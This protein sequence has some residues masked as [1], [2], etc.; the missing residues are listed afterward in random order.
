MAY[1]PLPE[2]ERVR[3]PKPLPNWYNNI[4]AVALGPASEATPGEPARANMNTVLHCLEKS[5][6]PLC[7]R[8]IVERV[9]QSEAR[10]GGWLM[11]LWEKGKITYELQ[12]AKKFWRLWHPGEV[13]TAPPPTRPRPVQEQI[14][15]H[16]AMT[17]DCWIQPREL[18]QRLG[19]TRTNQVVQSLEGLW[20]VGEVERR[21]SPTASVAGSRQHPYQY[22][23]VDTLTAHD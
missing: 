7:C 15:T 19:L 9:G 4:E 3:K 10:V 8:Q 2:H 21:P 13:V 11:R 12:G 23:L 17:P 16:L 5:P 6:T 1:P 22:R 14:R 20:R 18:Q